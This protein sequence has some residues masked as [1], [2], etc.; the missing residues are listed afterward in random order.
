VK[1]LNPRSAEDRRITAYTNL[2]YIQ[3]WE[4]GTI[5]VGHDSFD[6]WGKQQGGTKK[7]TTTPE[8]FAKYGGHHSY[9]TLELMQRGCCTIITQE[10]AELENG[11]PT[12]RGDDISEAMELHEKGYGIKA[13]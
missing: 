13:H 9:V 7:F 11:A 12:D 2:F 10:L 8:Y 3:P 5:Q 6:C 4:L 1:P